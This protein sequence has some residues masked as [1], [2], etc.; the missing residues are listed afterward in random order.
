MSPELKHGCHDDSVNYTVLTSG[1]MPP[2][3]TAFVCGLYVL[4][5][6]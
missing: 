6:I 4:F 2:V 3:K 1:R 5:Y